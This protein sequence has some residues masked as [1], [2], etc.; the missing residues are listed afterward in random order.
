MF[1]LLCNIFFSFEEKINYWELSMSEEICNKI[2]V[3]NLGY[4]G[5]PFTSSPKN[6]LHKM[7]NFN[8]SICFCF[9]CLLHQPHNCSGRLFATSKFYKLFIRDFT[10]NRMFSFYTFL[11]LK[12]FQLSF[13]SC[14]RLYY[15]WNEIWNIFILPLLS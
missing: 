6:S 3:Y 7:V 5:L 15:V 8:F 13:D 14:V 1:Y 2:V 12:I 9:V 11:K 4:D 10:G